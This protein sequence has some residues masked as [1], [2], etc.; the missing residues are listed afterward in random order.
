MIFPDRDLEIA[1]A[2]SPNSAVLGEPKRDRRPHVHTNEAYR[3][4]TEYRFVNAD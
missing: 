2:P 3:Q 4:T 1:Y